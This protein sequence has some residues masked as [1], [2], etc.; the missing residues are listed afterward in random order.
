MAYQYFPLRSAPASDVQLWDILYELTAA[1]RERELAANL[2]PRQPPGNW[3]WY[4]TAATDPNTVTAITA[5][6]ATVGTA[7]WAASRWFNFS[8]VAI[9]YAPQYYDVVFDHCN[10]KKVCRARILAANTATALPTITDLTHYVTERVI[11]ALNDLIGRH[12]YIIKRDGLWWSERIL[13]WPNDNVFQEGTATASTATTLTAVATWSKDQW[14]GFDVMFKDGG[15]TLRRGRVTGNTATTLTFTGAAA[16]VGKFYIVAAD[17]LFQWER[18]PGT[19]GTFTTPAPVFAWYRGATEPWWSHY[20]DDSLHVTQK[21]Q[22]TISLSIG[23]DPAACVTTTVTLFDVDFLSNVQDQCST[24]DKFYCPDIHKTLRH[25]QVRIENLIALGKYVDPTKTYDNLSYQADPFVLATIFKKAGINAQSVVSTG[26]DGAGL[27]VALSVPW[28]PI[29]VWW[30]VVDSA[31]LVLLSGY[32]AYDGT[33]IA[34]ASFSAAHDSKTV[35]VS[36]GWTRWVPREFRYWYPATAFIPGEDGGGAVVDPPDATHAGVW[37]TRPASDHYIDHSDYGFVADSSAARD[38][39]ANGDLA[40]YV[41]DN[42][43]DPAVTPNDKYAVTLARPAG[44]DVLTPYYDNFYRGRRA[45]EPVKSGTATGG[46]AWYLEDTT[47]NWWPGGVLRTETGTATGGSST[48][49]IDATKAGSAFWDPASGRW[50]GFIL[51]LLD[52]GGAVT[53]RLPITAHTGTT[54]TFTAVAGLTVAAGQ[55][56]RIREP[57]YVLNRFKGRTLRMGRIAYTITH[58]DDCRLYYAAGAGAGVGVAWS[59]DEVSPGTVWQR[60]AGAW[61]KPVGVDARSGAAAVKFHDN[62]TE[63]LPTMVKRYGRMM[64]GDYVLSDAPLTEI[65]TVLNL[66]VWTKYPVGWTNEFTVSV[67]ENNKNFGLFINGAYIPEGGGT[68]WTTI[69]TNTDAD[70]DGHAFTASGDPPVAYAVAQDDLLGDN[71]TGNE[72]GVYE[73]GVINSFPSGDKCP[74]ASAID[75]YAHAII[76]AGDPDDQHHKVGTTVIDTRFNSNGFNLHFRKYGKYDTT[77]PA[78][79]TRRLSAKLGPNGKPTWPTQPAW[80]IINEVT[81]DPGAWTYEAG[82]LVDA[83]YA[84]ARWNVA[85]GFKYFDPT[86]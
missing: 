42:W 11:N 62:Q 20:P 70:W 83:Q 6:S 30:A 33:Q 28:T 47:Q 12:V 19:P 3:E 63:N 35:I 71:A 51:E 80:P 76:K 5:T 82:F 58:S 14:R 1:A 53:Y 21:P 29:N 59:I 39:F 24:P 16:A 75:W 64:L 73:Y 66:M 85:G 56:Y 50:V 17:A 72:N 26:H 79:T 37:T 34:G 54:L 81:G 67:A 2:G 49:L 22:P 69:H 32:S 55:A 40:R 61:T 45:V 46:T 68:A 18:I 9:P 23:T 86:V 25:L 7:T 31:G 65:Y 38:A 41:A 27:N 60:T 43:C 13:E 57:K 10:P 44:Y 8:D 48:T 78:T 4:P 77:G 36:L 52:G 15:G 74:I 84:V